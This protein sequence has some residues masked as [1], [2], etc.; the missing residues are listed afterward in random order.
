MPQSFFILSKE[1]I[2]L[3]ADEVLAIAKTYDRFSKAQL[4]SNVL[5]IQSNIPWEKIAKRAVY[6][7]TGGRLLTKMSSI[8][9][10]EDNFISLQNSKTFSCRVLN[11]SNKNIDTIELEKMM[12]SMISKFTKAKVSL[13]NPNITIYL[14]F[15]GVLNFFGFSKKFKKS[16]RPKKI[17]KH[18]HELDWKFSR[19]MINL[20]GLKEDETV[21]DPFCGTGTTLLEAESMGI[22]SIGIDF[23]EKMCLISNKNALANNFQSEIINDDFNLIQKISSRFDGIVTD[24][25]YGKSS[26]SSEK[27]KKM[28]E[29]FVAT[30]PSRKKVVIMCKKGFERNI[31]FKPTK[32]YEIYRHKSL[33]RMILV[34]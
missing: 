11:L 20:A 6:V 5:I 21:C 14:V 18:P 19:L 31:K 29:K 24:V 4:F 10:D 9:L 28:F 32:K 15:T 25:P 17:S 1:N 22:H 8:F 16:P 33:T 13:D 2:D 3:A 7:K 12:G 30:I 34:K 26:K 27:P 23:D